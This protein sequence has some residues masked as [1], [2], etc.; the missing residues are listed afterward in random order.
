MTNRKVKVYGEKGEVS[1][2]YELDAKEYVKSG[3]Y[4]MTEPKV[5]PKRGP[6]KKPDP[7]P[8]EDLE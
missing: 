6:S 3:Y 8:E 1:E 2:V 7:K 4:S 5:K